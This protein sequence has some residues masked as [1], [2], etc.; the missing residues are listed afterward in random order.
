MM[1]NVNEDLDDETEEGM[2][3]VQGSLSQKNIHGAIIMTLSILSEKLSSK[4]LF[5]KMI[6]YCQ[7]GLGSNDWKA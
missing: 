5:L 7:E 3:F 1:K 4:Y 6:P 2:D